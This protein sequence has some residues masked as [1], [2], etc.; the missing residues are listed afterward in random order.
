M[1]KA[2]AGHSA[3]SLSSGKAEGTD[4]GLPLGELCWTLH[5][6]ATLSLTHATNSTDACGAEGRA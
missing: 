1:G 4:A 3:F 2:G 6:T 5:T